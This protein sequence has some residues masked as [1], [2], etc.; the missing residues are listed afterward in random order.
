MKRA[1]ASIACLALILAAKFA[2]AQKSDLATYM[3]K[4]IEFYQAK[5]S[6]EQLGE[7]LKVSY[8]IPYLQA[9]DSGQTMKQMN[10]VYMEEGYTVEFDI[11]L[12]NT[13]A[14]S[15]F[16]TS[17][18][19]HVSESKLVDVDIPYIQDYGYRRLQFGNIGWA[20]LD[21]IKASYSVL[22]P[23]ACDG[24]SPIPKPTKTAIPQKHTLVSGHEG[25]TVELTSGDI[26]KSFRLD[27][28]KPPTAHDQFG[29]VLGYLE[30]TTHGLPKR[31]PFAALTKLDGGQVA[32]VFDSTASYNLF[33]EA[34]KTNYTETLPISQFV[35]PN[36]P[37]RFTVRFRS[38]RS[39]SFKFDATLRLT[40]G[41]TLKLGTVDLDY[42]RPFSW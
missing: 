38:N 8:V 42:F 9:I 3:A 26:P 4:L 7:V 32:G 36:S 28:S 41:T 21:A 24:D 31:R 33:L 6:S 16:A 2:F 29:C 11:K 34:G 39:A 12:N 27:L 22:P 40:D 15:K 5:Y 23:E 13:T 37:D 30:Y 10:V 17:V 19:F 1:M 14:M 25:W 35:A 18:D 20:E